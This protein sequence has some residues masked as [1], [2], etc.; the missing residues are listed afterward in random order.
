M[1]VFLGEMLLR[2]SIGITKAFKRNCI[3]DLLSHLMK[4]RGIWTLG[5][6]LV[7]FYRTFFIVIDFVKNS[8][9]FDVLFE[10]A[11]KGAISLL[12]LGINHFIKATKPKKKWSTTMFEGRFNSAIV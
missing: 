9:N 1:E 12:Q 8:F 6:I 4:K 11:V 3:S 10:K 2:L 5:R 7:F